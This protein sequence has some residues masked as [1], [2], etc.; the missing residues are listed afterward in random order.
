MLRCAH[1]YSRVPLYCFL[2]KRSRIDANGSDELSAQQVVMRLAELLKTFN[3]RTYELILK[4]TAMEVRDTCH[5]TQLV[6]RANHIRYGRTD[7]HRSCGGAREHCFRP[8]SVLWCANVLT[9]CCP[10]WEA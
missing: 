4:G 10:R 8:Q 2:R 6:A 7:P 9:E 3:K 5:A 1:V